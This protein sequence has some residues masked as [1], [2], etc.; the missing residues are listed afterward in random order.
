MKSVRYLVILFILPSCHLLAQTDFTSLHPQPRQAYSRFTSAVFEPSPGHPIYLMPDTPMHW[1]AAEFNAFLRGKGKDT[2]EVRIYTPADSSQGGIFFGVCSKE[3]N[4]ML[5]AMEDQELQVTPAYPGP[6]GYAIDV[7][8][9]RML[10]NASDEAGLA[11]ALHTLRQ[12]LYPRE[13][14]W[15]LEG[16][17]IVDAPEL[18]IRW[19]YYPTNVLVGDNVTAAKALWTEAL[20]HR[21]NGVHLVD[22]KFS[23]PTTLPQRY[24]DSLAS[25]R[26]WARD[27]RLEVIPGVMP[28]G[29]SNSLLF[30]DPNLASGLP[31]QQQKFVIDADTARLV[32]R[33]DAGLPN[34]GFEQHTGDN[35]PGFRFIDQPGKISFVDTLVKHSGAASVRMENFAQHS[36]EHGHGR[37]SY[38]TRVTP[39]TQ[40][41]VSAWVKTEDLQPASA[42]NLSVLSNAGYNLAYNRFE[43]PSTTDWM[44]IDFTIN[45]LEADTVGLYWGVW[46]ATSGRIWWDDLAFEECAFVNLIR[47]E[48]APLTVGHPLLAIVYSEGTDFDT[49]RDAR[50]GNIPYGGSYDKWHTP[51]TL[52][53]AK[54]GMLKD[55]DT[56]VA[57][58]HHAVV[59][60]EGQ[61]AATMSHPAV[62]DILDRE[63]ALLDSVLR[64]DRLFMQHD[65]IRTMNWDAG[66]RARGLSPAEILADNVAQCTAIIEKHHPG[67]EVWVWTDMFDEFHN[68]VE[69][70]YYQVRG[71]L[72]GSADRI[73]QDIGMVNWNGREGIVQNSL[74]FFA[75]R[76]FRQISAPYYDSDER[77]IRRWREWT[78]GV[79]DFHG[80][81]YTT[82]QRKY[83]HLE[84]FGDY[85]WTHAPNIYHTPPWGL[86]PGEQLLFRTMI[87]GDRWDPDWKLT[88]A[89]I[90]WRTQPGD[91]FKES[92]FSATP[93]LLEETWFPVPAE[94][95][96]LQWYV[97]ASD[98]RGWTTRVP[99]ADTVY[100]ELGDFTTALS[101]ASAPAGMH[102]ALYPQPL[103]RDGTLTLEWSVPSGGGATFTMV[104]MLG[105]TVYTRELPSSAAGPNTTRFTMPDLADGM[106]VAILRGMSGVIARTAVLHR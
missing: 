68:A 86:R 76:G 89:A 59:I 72:R 47:R 28:F 85:A 23:R 104:D 9:W 45:T 75:Q 106:Y 25:L 11:Y 44:K 78:R 17:R 66:D 26:D 82:W 30:H 101:S 41:H 83:D 6:E 55:G 20:R 5:A 63:F 19:F 32:P 73:S 22:S 52:R 88:E 74:D 80:M 35:F 39:F 97:T 24:L 67:T 70:P 69:G 48:G 54:G 81:M 87:T 58:Y 1:A 13:G 79:P 77:Q 98:S 46:G 10:V 93:G 15:G 90:H 99:F 61:V 100:Y 31:V 21:L 36:P 57:S 84:P 33:I 95:T 14:W 38:W 56:V 105:R 27:R 96:W 62:Y 64:A 65:E 40:Y 53:A 91:P 12:M 16:C 71:D 34:G 18:P 42:I 3:I 50:M 51:P 29:Y 60:N 8:T 2:L 49:L 43:I 103:R 37:V 4:A 102:L 7:L 94:A 92:A